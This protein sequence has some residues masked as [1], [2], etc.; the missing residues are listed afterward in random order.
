MA[1]SSSSRKGSSR[2]M[3]LKDRRAAPDA[4]PS[5]LRQLKGALNR[6]IGLQRS[7]GKLRVVL[8]ERRRARPANEKPSIA[9]LCAELSA[10]LLAHEADE[11]AQAMR[12]LIL[13]HDALE[14]KGWPGIEQMSSLVLV[15]AIA[16]ATL[17]AHEEPS[18]HMDTL[19]EGLRPL[20][21]AAALRE[22]REA[23]LHEQRLDAS[24]VEVSESDYTEFE[25]AEQDW[26]GAT[27][28]LGL[29]PQPE[30]DD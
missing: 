18:P 17:L 7:E 15:K 22:Q 5:S 23:R 28:P 3:P 2:H 13:V 6:P 24:A 1:S 4:P 30:S 14:R 9:L 21:A 25:D 19:I 27:V 29:L 26:S 12:H 10:R 16:Q 20:Q 8:T 11:A